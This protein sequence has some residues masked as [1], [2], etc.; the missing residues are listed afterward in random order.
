MQIPLHHIMF[1]NLFPQPLLTMIPPSP[2]IRSS[3]ALMLPHQ[4]EEPQQHPQ[5][6]LA[7][8]EESQQDLNLVEET[9]HNLQEP[10]FVEEPQQQRH[11]TL[12]IEDKLTAIIDESQIQSPIEDTPQPSKTQFKPLQQ[13]QH[14]QPPVA[15]VLP[16]LPQTSKKANQRIPS[17]NHNTF[18]NQLL[19]IAR[20]SN[21][22]LLRR[23]GITDCSIIIEHLMTD[24]DVIEIG[25]ISVQNIAAKRKR[26]NKRDPTYRPS[27]RIRRQSIGWAETRELR[28]LPM[29][30]VR[31]LR[32]DIEILN[33]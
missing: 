12:V 31:S 6:D 16:Q 21:Q 1:M 22:E 26:K 15:F 33:E 4:A 23:H 9:Q 24:N 14:Q 13:R 18:S 32:D 7:L 8:V 25:E 17:T 2:W 11:E 10:N 19:L 28:S 29:R 20:I 3:V 30:E 5:Q 27:K